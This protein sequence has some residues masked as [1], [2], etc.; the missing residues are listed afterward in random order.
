MSVSVAAFCNAILTLNGQLEQ[1][2]QIVLSYTALFVALIY[3]PTFVRAVQKQGFLG[4]LLGFFVRTAKSAPGIRNVVEN[5]LDKGIA[6]IVRDF[7]D[8]T[9]GSDAPEMR[10]LRLP[11]HG[12]NRAR[13]LEVLRQWADSERVR[14]EGGQQSGAVYCGDPKFKDF[15]NEANGLFSASNPLH[16]MVFPYTRQMEAEVVRMACNMFN[17]DADSCGAMSSGGTESILLACK[18]YRDLGRTRGIREPEMIVPIT[19][20]AAFAKACHLFGIKLVEVAVD[21]QTRE[22]EPRDMER[23]I[24]RNT[25]LVVGSA[26]NYPYGSMDPIP[27]LSEIAKKHG[28]GFHVD[29]C[30]GG[31]LLP[32][33][34]K[35]GFDIPLFDFRLPGVSSISA[36]THKYGYAP[37]GSSVIMYRSKELRHHQYMMSVDWTGGVYATATFPGS[38][39]GGAIA[40]TWAAMVAMGQ[41]GY[42]ASTREVITTT[43]RIAKGIQSIPGLYVVGRPV[44]SVVAFASSEPAMNIYAVKDELKRRSWSLNPLQK[45][46]CIHLCCTVL[47]NGRADD[48]LDDV[49]AACEVVRED[50]SLNKQG[51]TALYG[52]ANLLPAGAGLVEQ[53]ATAYLD[54]YYDVGDAEDT[55]DAEDLLSSKLCWK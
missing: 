50:P 55:G 31:F 5:E 48:F 44:A 43:R 17:G 9:A 8:C 49:K 22:V 46:A 21:E 36:D 35:V 13:I 30:L 39:P 45:P 38:R 4:T 14:W 41:D 6:M 10:T 26:P 3:G 11:A 34:E 25:V 40:S 2:W 27:A 42:E 16:A 7:R 53:L 18:T 52:V 12:V 33:M 51:S 1:P 29:C 47:L 23:N 15:L 32:F 54:C 37:K 20:H 24:T 19:A 28:I